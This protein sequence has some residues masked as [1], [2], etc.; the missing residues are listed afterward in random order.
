MQSFNGRYNRF[1][2]L[3]L[4]GKRLLKLEVH[5]QKVEQQ[6]VVEEAVAHLQ[7]SVELQLR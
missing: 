7:R 2:M 3:V 5:L 6:W 4:S 1:K